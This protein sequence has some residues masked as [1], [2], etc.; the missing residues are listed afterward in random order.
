MNWKR[1]Q[2]QKNQLVLPLAW[3]S[4]WGLVLFKSTQEVEMAEL[5]IYLLVYLFLSWVVFLL[6]LRY[7]DKPLKQRKGVLFLGAGIY[8]LPLLLAIAKNL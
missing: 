5:V 1:R 4:I 2:V 7:N 6:F 3:L 8:L